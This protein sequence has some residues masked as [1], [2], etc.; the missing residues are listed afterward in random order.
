MSSQLFIR[1][2]DVLVVPRW[3]AI[4]AGSD[5]RAESLFPP[6]PRHP[7]RHPL[8]SIGA[9][10]GI[11]L[12]DPLAIEKAVGKPNDYGALRLRGP[13]LAKLDDQ[14]IPVRYFPQPADAV[15]AG[16]MKI[17]PAG[18]PQA[19]RQALPPVAQRPCCW[20]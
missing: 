17:K 7:G 5:H 20:A 8:Q 16:S 1:P 12:N 6:Y 15:T 11:N 14:G 10:G 4:S 19:P 9:P 13:F 18:K 2:V 3:A